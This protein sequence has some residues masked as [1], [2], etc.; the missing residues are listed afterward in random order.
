[1]SLSPKI[2]QAGWYLCKVQHYDPK[3]T[4]TVVYSDGQI[5]DMVNI[6]SV[7]WIPAAQKRKHFVPLAQGPPKPSLKSNP[8]GK[9]K[10]AW[11]N[12]HKVKAFADDLTLISSDIAAHQADLLS[13]DS[14]CL[15]LG[16]EIRPDKCTSLHFTGKKMSTTVT[17]QLNKGKTSPLSAFPI[18]FLGCTLAI[19]PSETKSASSAKLLKRFST[20]L[21]KID[22][23]PIRG[24]FKV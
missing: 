12:E 18:S 6:H 13:L 17:V 10:F 5:E 14:A 1:M 4:A 24:E 20:C 19:S 15:E 2:P 23:R 16:L 21:Q 8:S 3:G 11:S 22:Q 7:Q 9:V